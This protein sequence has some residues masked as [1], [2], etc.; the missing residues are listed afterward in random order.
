MNHGRPAVLVDGGDGGGVVG[1]LDH[2]VLLW[3]NV[4]GSQPDQLKRRSPSGAFEQGWLLLAC[5][6]L[7]IIL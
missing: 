6:Y 7:D 5:D 4:L 1:E 2:D 3:H